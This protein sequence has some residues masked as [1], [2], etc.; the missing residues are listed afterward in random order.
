MAV[1]DGEPMIKARINP[2]LCE[3]ALQWASG[4][5]FTSAVLSSRVAIGGEGLVTRTLRRLDELMR[6]ITFV[7]RHDLASPEA[8]QAIQNARLLARRGVLAAPSAYLGEAEDR[9]AEEIEAEPPWPN[10]MWPPGHQ[11]DLDPLDLGFSQAACSRKFRAPPVAGGPEHILGLAAALCDG[12]IRSSDVRPE[13][14]YWFRHRF[15]SLDNRR[16]AAFR[17][18][19]LKCEDAKVLVIVLN[20]RQGLEQLW[21]RKFSTGFT[22]GQKIRITQTDRFV[23]ITREQC[24]YGCNLWGANS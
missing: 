9:V 21:L 17:L 18:F 5:D 8:A 20:R 23:G 22:G 12:S 4:Q 2:Q 3:T 16:L 13:S 6:E 19:R 11:G 15:Y 24:T 14:I 1:C 7:L 10:Q